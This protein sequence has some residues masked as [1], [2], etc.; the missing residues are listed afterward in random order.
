VGGARGQALTNAR[1]FAAVGVAAL[2][3]GAIL[4][5]LGRPPGRAPAAAEAPTIAAPALYAATFMDGSGIP[6]SLGQH[7]GKVVVLN[8]W[9]TWCEPCRAEMP[10]FS[11]LHERWS[12]R[13]V[14][15]LG[16]SDEPPEKAATFGR[17][18]GIAY[19]LWTGGDQVA[20]L[21][22]RLGNSAGGLPHTVVVN[23]RGGVIA[24][25]VGPYTEAE[26][27]KVLAVETTK[28]Q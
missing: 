13:G 8:F 2:A 12:G 26:L 21:S 4:W 24:Q 22:R 6:R 18:L 7:E 5:H 14:Q 28:S 10:A 15:F 23:S 19:P 20:D 11:R 1:L 27:E 3:A 16:L 25:R 9:A 17:A